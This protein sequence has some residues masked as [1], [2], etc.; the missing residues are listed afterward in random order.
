MANSVYLQKVL[1]TCDIL[2]LQEHWMMSF[3]KHELDNISDTHIVTAK[4]VD[5]GKDDRINFMNIRAYGGVAIYW[6]KDINHAIQVKQ[7]GNITIHAQPKSICLI[8][9][10]PLSENKEADEQ[11]KDTLEQISEIIQ[12]FKDTH[13]MLICGNMNASLH[14]DNRTKDMNYKHFISEND[15]QMANQYPC[16]STFFHHNGKSESQIDYF[17]HHEQNNVPYSVKI[18]DMDPINVSDHTMISAT[19][20]LSLKR[21]KKYTELI[22]SKPKWKKM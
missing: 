7:D 16:K 10:Y 1:N 5:E 15:L 8:N 3:E 14:R 12:K 18:H 17:I 6:R 4:S 20:E 2:C 19:L 22:I 9:A 21:I 11:Y 13:N